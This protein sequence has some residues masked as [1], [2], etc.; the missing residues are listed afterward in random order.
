[1]RY[2]YQQLMAFWLVILVTLLTSGFAF[3]QLT[4]Q[5]METN[6]YR[7]LFGYAE[8]VTEVS[9]VISDSFSIQDLNENVIEEKQDFFYD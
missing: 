8:A 7:Q 1:M 6:N 3:I 2:L 9:K 4:K 5:S